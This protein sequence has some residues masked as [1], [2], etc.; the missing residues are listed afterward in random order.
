[1]FGMIK[2]VIMSIFNWDLF[3]NDFMEFWQYPY[4]LTL[5]DAFWPV[6]FTGVFGLAYG[7]SRDLSVTTAAILLTFGIFSTTEVFANN[8]EYSLFF[9]IIASAG[10]AGAVAVLF[11]KKSPGG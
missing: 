8:P 11:F 1:M 2:A 5:G 3:S 6:V 7:I 10:Y 4:K 9:S